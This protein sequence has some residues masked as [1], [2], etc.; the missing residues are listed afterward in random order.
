MRSKKVLRGTL[1]ITLASL[2]LMST[3]ACGGSNNG[4]NGSSASNNGTAN[5]N[6]PATNNSTGD[7]AAANT[8]KDTAPKEEPV[9]LTMLVN[10]QPAVPF[11]DT[12][13]GKE[14]E[15]KLNIKVDWVVAEDEKIKVLLAS[16]DLPDIIMLKPEDQARVIEG[17]QVIPMDDMLAEKGQ[18]IT[19]NTPQVVDFM[20]KFRSNGSNKLY[21][22]PVN[23]GP[24]MM[25]FEASLGVVTRWDYYKELGYPAINSED[26]LLN[27]LK[28]MQDKHPKTPEGNKTYGVAAWNDWGLWSYYMPM[29]ILYGYADWGNNGYVQTSDTNEIVNNYTNAD[30]PLWKT[31]SFYYKARKMGLL[32]PDSLTMQSGDFSAKMATGQI[33][34]S[35]ASWF[36][37][38]FNGKNNANAAGYVTL[39]LEW[40]HQWNG[41][42]QLGWFD[43]SLGI[44]KN[45]KHPDRA[46]ELL[47]YLWSYEGSRL[48]YSGVKGTDWD[49]VGGVP[50]IS[51]SMTKARNEN[52]EA[53]QKTGVRGAQTGIYNGLGNFVIDPDDNTEVDLFSSA[54]S[55]NALLDPLSKDYTDH[56]GVTY[57]AEIFLK[58]VEAGK[59]INQ[60][61]MDTRIAAALPATPD[62]ISR[63]DAKLKDLMTKAV[64]KAIMADSDEK[65]E[66]AKQK[67]MDDLKAA[68]VDK[69]NDWWVKAWND[70]KA[71]VNG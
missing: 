8:Q 67:T 35:P 54:K 56:Y 34:Y 7:N 13:V 25:G 48:A 12:E 71:K 9:T 23:S 70:T 15:K 30:S 1:A 58:N 39:P 26:D 57:P 20:R 41:A 16:G 36:N 11:S 32:D 22:L 69:S 14:I 38:T 65:F 40:G 47:N 64:A 37:G 27:V 42:N 19:K 66:Q 63:I 51:E 60:K 59:S 33:L 17:G 68:G 29:A 61:D 62:D 4:N 24:D 6:Q 53:Y 10:Q 31:V 52:G 2:L 46:M 44:T 50:T 43:K 45:S 49:V 3:A 5:A 18:E 55:F 21:F 28:Q